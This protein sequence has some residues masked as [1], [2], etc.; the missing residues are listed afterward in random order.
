MNFDLTEEQNLTR[1]AVRD[2]AEKE[3]APLAQELDEK[4]E[5]SEA[6]TQKMGQLGL[7]GCFVSEKY[8]GSNMGYISYIIAVEELARV[9]G[10]QA[11]TIA[12]GNS[13]GIGPIHYF[14]S[15]E[16]KK[17]WLPRLCTGEMAGSDAGSSRTRG[18]LKGDSW[19]INGSKI[20]ITNSANPLTGLVIVQA[21][22]G[23]KTEGKREL[24]CIIVPKGAPGF[25][26]REMKKKMMWRASN[27]GELFFEDCVVP[28]ENLLGQRG[29]GLHQM[30]S[31]LDG[32]RL[33]IGAMG[34][35]GAQ[36]AFEMAL[37]YANTR[38]QFG[39]PISSFQ[40]NA[41]KLA[42]MALEIELARNIL[43]K[44]CWLRENSRPFSKEAA[45]AKLYS[46]E[47]M[48]RCVNHAVQ[49][50]GGYGLMKDYKIERFY[51]D[52]K[53]LEIGEGTSEIQRIV[54]ARSIGAAGRAI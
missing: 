18:E 33:S 10:S 22:T 25:T 44:A 20:F 40:G 49:L 16:Q 28:G 43:Y 30:L 19:V 51:R 14:G 12:A 39:R 2:F 36:G 53:L 3:I 23:M 13:L 17:E 11:A 52:Q 27:T 31:T 7:L 24:S 21:I 48:G 54:I 8:G 5:F 15:E 26:A 29:D 1:Q 9:D 34:L 50:H 4:E 32:G 6:L 38:I 37:Q 35:G 42:D 46:S 47:V 41:F 45:M